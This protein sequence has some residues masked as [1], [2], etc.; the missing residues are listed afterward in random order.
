MTDST[1]SWNAEIL[2]LLKKSRQ[3][4]VLWDITDVQSLRPDL[5]DEQAWVVLQAADGYCDCQICPHWFDFDELAE[6]LFPEPDEESSEG[7]SYE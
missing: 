4:A 2:N 1:D 3:I 6:Q 7:D 5:S